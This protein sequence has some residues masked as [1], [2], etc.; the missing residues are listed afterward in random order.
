M[1]FL[2]CKLGTNFVAVLL[3]MWNFNV[4]STLYITGGSCFGCV[5]LCGSKYLNNSCG[6]KAVPFW[7]NQWKK[8]CR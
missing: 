4:L 7:K 3:W 2:C 1:E 8:V 5:V 6:E